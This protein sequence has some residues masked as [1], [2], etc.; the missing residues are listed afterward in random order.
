M[1]YRGTIYRPCPKCCPDHRVDFDDTG[2]RTAEGHRVYACRNCWHQHV[3]K[4]R[5]VKRGDDGMTA[6]QRRVVEKLRY[7]IL[8]HDGL[9][10]QFVE[11]HEYKRFD[12]EVKHGQVYLLTEVGR[13]NDEGTAAAI[14][15]RTRRHIA[16][17]PRGALKLLNPKREGH[18]PL[19]GWFE[20]VHAQTM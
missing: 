11:N 17:G 10:A 19:R 20:V 14:L 7:D 6:K 2:D 15:C 13:K 12:V 4:P 16:I 1:A 9:G 8:H 18:K 3:V 5:K